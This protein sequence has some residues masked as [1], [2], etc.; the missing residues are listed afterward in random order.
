MIKSII[1][2]IINIICVLFAN[3]KQS[4]VMS[5]AERK[6]DGRPIFS[7]EVQNQKYFFLLDTGYYKTTFNER[8]SNEFITDN[9]IQDK[10]ITG[11][12]YRISYLPVFDGIIGNNI[13]DKYKIITI[14]YKNKRIIFEDLELEA[15]QEIPLEKNEND[16]GIYIPIKF[17]GDEIKAFVD[18]GCNVGGASYDFMMI[19]RK[20]F[21]NQNEI[22]LCDKV[23]IGDYI[24][25]NVYC[26]CATNE[27]AIISD[28]ETQIYFDGI[29]LL[30]STFF[31]DRIIQFDFNKM[32]FRIK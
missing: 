12:E 13:F 22:L 14:D 10:F 9:F 19:P 3:E 32:V 2:I 24:Y 21:S 29:F 28:K 5:F 7:M 25:N 23:E 27:A 20:Y 31:R 11:S 8:T 15:S 18:T 16:C 26:F 1:A 17:D 30:P 4:I 6:N